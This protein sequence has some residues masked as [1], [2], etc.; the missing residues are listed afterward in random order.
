MSTMAVDIIL[1]L[2]IGVAWLWRK[3]C[4]KVLGV[5]TVAFI[6][7]IVAGPLLHDTNRHVALAAID[8]VIVFAMLGIWTVHGSMRAYSVGLIGLGK[9]IGR[10]LFYSAPFTNHY[11]FAVAINCAFALQVVAAG[12][13]LDVLGRWL[14]RALRSLM[15]RRYR[16]LFHGKG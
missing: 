15:P 16:L 11:V 7:A 9:L 6:A 8:Y 10:T 3:R 14:D 12:G 1:G 5:L 13:L 4:D 2:L